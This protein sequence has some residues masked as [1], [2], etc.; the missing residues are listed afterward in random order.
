[1][2]ISLITLCFGIF[3]RIGLYVSTCILAI[4]IHCLC[5]RELSWVAGRQLTQLLRDHQVFAVCCPQQRL[6]SE[7]CK[8]VLLVLIGVFIYALKN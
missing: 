2:L 6:K 1:M 3:G 7:L 8:S 5:Y 4:G